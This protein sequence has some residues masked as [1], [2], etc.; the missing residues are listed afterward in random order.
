MLLLELSQCLAKVGLESLSL[1]HLDG[2]GDR[3][4][5]ALGRLRLIKRAATLIAP[6]LVPD[7]ALNFITAAHTLCLFVAVL[8]CCDR[9]RLFTCVELI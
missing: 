7:T 4:G 3:A 9:R 5:A 8:F 6:R 1:R 2:V